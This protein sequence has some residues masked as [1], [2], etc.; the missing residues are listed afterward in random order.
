MVLQRSLCPVPT[1]VPLC[2]SVLN[3]FWDLESLAQERKRSWPDDSEML[4]AFQWCHCINT[5]N[6]FS[7]GFFLLDND[8]KRL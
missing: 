1:P 8:S 2:S 5:N 6:K 7:G 4:H 3:R